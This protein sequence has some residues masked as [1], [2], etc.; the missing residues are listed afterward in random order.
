M[1]PWPKSI[2][3][4]VV[5]A[6]RESALPGI[7]VLVQ[8]VAPVKNNYSLPVRLT[9]EN[10]RLEFLAEEIER[11]VREE[12]QRYPMDYGAHLE[13]CNE[14]I[15]TIEDRDQLATRTERIAKYFPR[16]AGELAE[17][18]KVCRNDALQPLIERT[19]VA[20][21]ILVSVNVP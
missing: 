12:Q 19:A 16:E 20:P 8:V 17:L 11:T 7:L 4:R 14:L 5:D 13:E 9:D 1:N 10:G 15:I 2:E 21:R 18:V 3:I 6:R